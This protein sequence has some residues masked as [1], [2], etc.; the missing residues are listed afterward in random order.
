[1]T[2]MKTFMDAFICDYTSFP[3]KFE[4][5][6]SLE[7]LSDYHYIYMGLALLGVGIYYPLSTYL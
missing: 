7:C 3:Y 1:M 6:T 2:V 5:N 4:R